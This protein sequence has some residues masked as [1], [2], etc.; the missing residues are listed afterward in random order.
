MRA[1][2]AS[3]QLCHVRPGCA[4]GGGRPQGRPRLPAGAC[5]GLPCRQA[6][7][8]A[9][10]GRFRGLCAGLACSTPGSAPWGQREG[11]CSS[12]SAAPGGR[13]CA[14]Q[15]AGDPAADWPPPPCPQ[16]P[17]GGSSSSSCGVQGRSSC[18]SDAAVDV[19]SS[20]SAHVGA[21]NGAGAGASTG[22]SQPTVQPDTSPGLR[23]CPVAGAEQGEAGEVQGSRQ[24]PEYK[25]RAALQTAAD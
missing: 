24:P 21:A 18:R 14:G 9:M 23:L 12:G 7:P 17:T 1:P 19:G 10:P 6:A 25:V 13:L 11:V 2:A 15:V 4:L 8:A 5:A 3:L 20:S 22:R 16:N